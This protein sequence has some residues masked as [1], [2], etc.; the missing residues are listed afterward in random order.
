MNFRGGFL[1]KNK[2]KELED[3]IYDLGIDQFQFAK[4]DGENLLLIGS[5]NI[6]Y[7]HLVEIT[8][9]SVDYIDCPMRFWST[10]T[11]KIRLATNEERKEFEKK[12]Q[13]EDADLM[14]FLEDE[15]FII[16]EKFEYRFADAVKNPNLKF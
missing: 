15:Y 6:A 10:S 14:I 3:K 2:I 4:F 9:V 11:L 8:F 16:C 5:P 13:V 7:Y 12:T 1:I